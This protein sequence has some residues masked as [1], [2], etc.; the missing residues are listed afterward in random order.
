MC[1]CCRYVVQN[2]PNLSTLDMSSCPRLTDAGV[3]QLGTP[4]A[5]TVST[6]ITLDLAGC[7][8]LTETALEYLSRCLSLRRIDLRHI[9]QISAEAVEK[10]ASA[11]G[12]LV[13]DEKLMERKWIGNKGIQDKAISL[14][15]VVQVCWLKYFVRTRIL[16]SY[17][18]LSAL[19]ALSQ[20]FITVQFTRVYTTVEVL[21]LQIFLKQVY[22]C[23]LKW[24]VAMLM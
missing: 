4:P 13:T 10:F 6:L 22:T 24:W 1:L 20:S 3:A 8:L 2:L 19:L 18:Q 21:Q 5:S 17:L 12:M 11:R 7:R 23:Q 15:Q 14:S 9:T 16:N